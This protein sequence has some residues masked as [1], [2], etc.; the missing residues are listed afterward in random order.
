MYIDDSKEREKKEEEGLRLPPT[1]EWFDLDQWDGYQTIDF[2]SSYYSFRL[3]VIVT[4]E[5]YSSTKY[6]TIDVVVTGKK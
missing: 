2:S 1:N 6:D 3:K 4:D 5:Y